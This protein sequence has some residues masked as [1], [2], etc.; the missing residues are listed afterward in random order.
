[1]TSRPAG[2]TATQTRRSARRWWWAAGGFVAAAAA[3]AAGAWIVLG[4]PVFGVT[5]VSV[6]GTQ[7]VAP[8]AVRAAAAVV[9][10]T[11]LARVDTDAVAD[12]VAGL[13]RVADVAVVRRWPRTL[14]VVVEERAAVAVVRERADGAPA[15]LRLVDGEGVAFAR[16]ADPPDRLPRL[17]AD[18]KDPQQSL[19]AALAVLDALP[20]PLARQVRVI[21]ASTPDDV[22]LELDDGPTVV[23]GSAD[24]S[25]R[26]ALVL[27]AI[28]RRPADVYDVSAPD[29]PT[30]R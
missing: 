8:H 2:A 23:W 14:A 28:M 3:G 18:G 27:G 6:E 24:R 9:P 16:V 1:M 29:V 4:S 30:T 13:A 21:T 7:T 11:P 15:R 19:Q 26:K 10:G 17:E 20:A 12:R 25:E 22:T 5:Q